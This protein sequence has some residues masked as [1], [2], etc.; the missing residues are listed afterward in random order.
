MIKF[1]MSM[2]KDT[3][4]QCSN[5]KLSRDPQSGYAPCSKQHKVKATTGAAAM[6]PD[7]NPPRGE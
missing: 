7:V 4:C 5:C 2:F 3:L 1:I 6:M